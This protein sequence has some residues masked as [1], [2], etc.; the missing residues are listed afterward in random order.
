MTKRIQSKD[1][2]WKVKLLIKKEK[3]WP[4]LAGQPLNLLTRLFV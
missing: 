4:D 1:K 2:N 3:K